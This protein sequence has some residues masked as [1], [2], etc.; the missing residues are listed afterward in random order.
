VC[1]QPLGISGAAQQQATEAPAAAAAAGAAA[2]NGPSPPAKGSVPSA[3]GVQG[4]GSP[5]AGL[6]S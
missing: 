1:L 4:L 5:G 6:G 2:T 3:E